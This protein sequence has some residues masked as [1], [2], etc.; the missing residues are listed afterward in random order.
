M[1]DLRK[2]ADILRLTLSYEQLIRKGYSRTEAVHTLSCQNRD[3]RRDVLEALVFLDPNA[4]E[5][6]IRR[7]RI[8]LLTPGMII[9]QE[10]RTSDGGLVVSK[11]QAVTPPLVMKLKNLHARRAINGEVSGS[12]PVSALSFV[13]GAVQEVLQRCALRA[14]AID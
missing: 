8:E 11:G 6:E 14:H 1:A 4:E 7:C 10:V 2:G 3:S 5:D 12:L 13:K 9:Q